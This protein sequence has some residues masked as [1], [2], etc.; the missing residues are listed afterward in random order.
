ILES[1][2]K[3]HN[4][5]IIDIETNEIIGDCG[6]EG[7]NHLNQTSE[8]GIYIGNKNYWNNGYGTEALSL[9]LNYGFKAL[10]FHNIFLQVVS[11]NERAIRSYEKI[12][13]KVIGK[14]R[15]A[16]LRGTKRHDMLYM[17]ILHNE[18]YEKWK[19]GIK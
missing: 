10:N 12:G 9:L 8:V 7:I 5:S 2:A 4:Y 13:F 19:N 17:D 15:E 18:F 1:A 11:F 16:I 3:D 6:F 14:K